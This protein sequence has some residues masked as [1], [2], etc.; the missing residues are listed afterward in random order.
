V[1]P[2]RRP[3]RS[4]TGE[5]FALA[6]GALLWSALFLLTLMDSPPELP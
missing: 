1:A 2:K 4:I 3:G 5:T 6:D